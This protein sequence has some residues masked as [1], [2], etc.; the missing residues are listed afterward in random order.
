MYRRKDFLFSY[1]FYR[2]ARCF[3]LVRRSLRRYNPARKMSTDTAQHPNAADLARKAGVRFTRQRC[4]VLQTVLDAEDHPTAALIYERTLQ[5][6]PGLSLATVY[7]ALE[8]L[9]EAGLINRLHF[10]DGTARYCKNLVPHVHLIDEATGEVLDIH[11]KAGLCAEDIFELPAGVRITG[12]E[13]CLRGHFSS[14]TS[15]S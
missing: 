12:M 14:K 2:P 4:A 5:Q 10:D 13:A 7:N 9:H 11:L 8:T 6:E 1:V 3:C 15:T